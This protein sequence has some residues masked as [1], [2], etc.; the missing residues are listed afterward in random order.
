MK[1]TVEINELWKRTIV[2]ESKP[3]ARYVTGDEIRRQAKKAM[4]EG[5]EGTLEF[6]RTLELEDWTTR[7]SPS[8]DFIGSSARVEV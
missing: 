8:G 5:D 3:G 1:F 7:T 2:V 4:E 6:S